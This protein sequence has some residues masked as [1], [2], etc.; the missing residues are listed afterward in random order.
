MAAMGAG[1]PDADLAAVLTYIRGAWGNGMGEVTADDVKE[2]RASLGARP[3]MM[4]HD[5][6]MAVPE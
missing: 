3:Q 4:T 6:L 1:L 2:V 5:M